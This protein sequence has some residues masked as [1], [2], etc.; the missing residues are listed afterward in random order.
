MKALTVVCVGGFLVCCFLGLVDIRT[1]EQKQIDH[2]EELIAHSLFQ[3]T[4]EFV[5]S[6]ISYPQS[7]QRISCKKFNTS[8]GYKK[9]MLI[10]FKNN[11]PSDCYFTAIG[12]SYLKV[13]EENFSNLEYHY[14]LVSELVLEG[15][16]LVILFEEMG[17]S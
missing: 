1:D 3:E 16:D 4:K 10:E 12:N 14:R 17:N 8:N 13:P 15:D 5:K 2:R 11:A 9:L 7:I 6:K